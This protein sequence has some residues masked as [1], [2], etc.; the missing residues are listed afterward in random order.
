MSGSVLSIL[1]VAELFEPGAAPLLLALSM[2]VQL[3]TLL[4]SLMT[5]S[6]PL[7]WVVPVPLIVPAVAPVQLMA[8][9]LL[10]P[11]VVSFAVTLP[12]IPLAAS[13]ALNQ[14]FWLAGGAGKLT[15]TSG[16]VVSVAPSVK[17]PVVCE[18]S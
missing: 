3:T 5:V 17:D 13:T 8:V 15:V 7:A 11:V 14:P 12:T 9:I 18:G 10:P 4:P 1:I 2:A 6:D 16:A